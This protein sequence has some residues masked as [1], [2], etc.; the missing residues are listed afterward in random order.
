MYDKEHKD[1]HNWDASEDRTI[2]IPPTQ[3]TE[4]IEDFSKLNEK[5]Q[6]DYWAWKTLRGRPPLAQR[7]IIVCLD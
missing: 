7:K 3:N 5:D 4:N 1:Y 6:N 2:P